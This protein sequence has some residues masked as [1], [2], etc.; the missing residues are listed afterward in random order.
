[1]EKKNTYIDL[2]LYDTYYIFAQIPIQA[3]S[4][5]RDHKLLCK[6]TQKRKPRK[7]PHIATHNWKFFFPSLTHARGLLDFDFP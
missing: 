3:M 2:L 1:M 4:I 6:A 5:Q 7:Q